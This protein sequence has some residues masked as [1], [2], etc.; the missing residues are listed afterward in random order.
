MSALHVYGS[1]VVVSHAITSG[2]ILRKHHSFTLLANK[3]SSLESLQCFDAVGWAAGR[4]S[5]L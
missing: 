1:S 2:A 5:G 3:L 4:A